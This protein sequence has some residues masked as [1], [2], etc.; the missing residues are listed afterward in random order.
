MKAMDR[1]DWLGAELKDGG[2]RQIVY[3]IVTASDLVEKHGR[4]R[5]EEEMERAKR[6]YPPFG[7]FMDKLMVL[8]GVLE[9]QPEDDERKEDEQ[10]LEEWLG[11]THDRE[12]L[13]Q[14][15]V[16]KTIPRRHVPP[17][18]A[19][20]KA[21]SSSSSSSSSSSEED[22]EEESSEESDDSGD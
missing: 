9:R 3:G 13:Q 10:P 4:T 7:L 1:S 22:S 11:E 16:L 21:V 19:E 17:I 8:S 5:Q 2:L 20:K 18:A 12:E 14:S 15:L 6:E